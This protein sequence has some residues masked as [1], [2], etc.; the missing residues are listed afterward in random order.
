MIGFGRY[1]LLIKLGQGGMGSVYLARQKALRRFCAVKIMNPEFSKNPNAVARFLLEARAAAAFTHPHLVSIFDCDK[2]DDQTLIAMEFVEG[3]SLA[4]VIRYSKALPLSLSLF[5]L[6]QAAIALEYVHSKNVIHRDIKPDNMMIDAQGNLKIMDLGLAKAKDQTEGDHSMTATGVIMGS[7]HYMSPEQI[8]DSKTVDHRTDLYSLGITLYQMVRGSLP[9]NKTSATA[10]CMAHLSEEIPSVEFTDPDLTMAMDQLIKKMAAKD[11]EERFQSA[12]EIIE[13]IKPWMEA[14]PMDATAQEAFSKL[15][16]EERKV[17]H[18][19]EKAKI[20][21][22]EVD[23]D[24]PNSIIED[25]TDPLKDPSLVSKTKNPTIAAT[26]PAPSS[27][28]WLYTG[29]AAGVLILLLVGG[30]IF[31]RESHTPVTP[32]PPVTQIAPQKSEAPVTGK[33]SITTAPTHA[34]I[35]WGSEVKKSPAEFSNVKPGQHKLEISL[36]GYKPTHRI[37]EVI[38][39]ETASLNVE[40][41]AIEETPAPTAVQAV[42]ALSIKTIPEGATIVFRGKSY[43]SNTIVQEIPVGEYEI[44]VTQTGYE[45]TSDKVSIEKDKPTTFERTLQRRKIALT[46]DTEPTGADIW[47]DGK[48]IGQTPKEVEAFFGDNIEYRFKITG[49]EETPFLIRFT[50]MESIK[51]IPLIHL[52][53][54]GQNMGTMPPT[55][56]TVYFPPESPQAWWLKHLETSQNTKSESEWMAQRKKIMEEVSHLLKNRDGARNSS[57]LTS[58]LNEMEKILDKTHSLPAAEFSQTKVEIINKLM[59]AY[60]KGIETGKKPGGMQPQGPPR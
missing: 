23:T 21:M 39:G 30:L 36:E 45:D 56:P 55:M 16:F 41:T 12:A 52:F 60:M 48:L 7:P 20:S 43:I 13:A 1:N 34:T 35:T 42:G 51:K 38:A 25:G 47:K 5:W 40:L 32:P 15:N 54:P 10:V 22:L 24:A 14:Y 29:L 26:Q 9:F 3:M 4:Q 31:S 8:N 28:K 46:L 53:N 49:F 27:N 17:A 50:G 11:K 18:I 2:F 57:T 6:N 59:A 58:S 44:L 33:I 37:I 19:L